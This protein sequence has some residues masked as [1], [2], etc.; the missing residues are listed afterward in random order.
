MLLTGGSSVVPGLGEKILEVVKSALNQR[1]FDDSVV[2]LTSLM[3]LNLSG[4]AA[5]DANRLA[6]ALGAAS[7]EFPGLNYY[8]EL[9]P[10]MPHQTVV[11]QRG[12]T[13]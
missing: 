6:V 5:A 9:A 1:G 7:E 2:R 4:P 10:A 12:W 13:G 8:S 11:R 3:T